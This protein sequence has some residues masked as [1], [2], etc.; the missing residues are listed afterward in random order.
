LIHWA[1]RF[2]VVADDKPEGRPGFNYFRSVGYERDITSER[3][4]NLRT[5]EKLVIPGHEPYAFQL[6]GGPCEATEI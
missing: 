4:A 1:S 5:L 2:T 6:S 3:T